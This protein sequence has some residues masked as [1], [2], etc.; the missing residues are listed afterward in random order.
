MARP[1][2]TPP[3]FVPTLTE[4]VQVD[5]LCLASNPGALFVPSTAS[6]PPTTPAPGGSS[7]ALALPVAGN[8]AVGAQALPQAPCIGPLVAAVGNSGL[9]ARAP[10]GI[11]EHM[12]RCVLQRV[13]E[14][15]DQRLREAM[16]KVIDEQTLLLARRLR[17][18]LETVVRDTVYEA[19]ADELSRD[20]P[21]GVEE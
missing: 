13:D 2:K 10:A 19:V 17:E 14:L 18:E 5:G 15:L 1:T 11:E 20:A 21:S 8:P 12:V 6:S 7:A 3:R 16:A 9:S 4:V